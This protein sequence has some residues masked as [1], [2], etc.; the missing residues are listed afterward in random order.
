MTHAYDALMD[1]L[2]ALAVEAV[3][4]PVTAVQSYWLILTAQQDS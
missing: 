2:A 1:S 3:R 4:T